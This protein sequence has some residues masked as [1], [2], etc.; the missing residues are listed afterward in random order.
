M[1]DFGIYDFDWIRGTTE[2]LVV[3][4]KINDTPIAADDV[5]LSVYAGNKLAFRMSSVDNPGAGPGMVNIDTGVYTFQPTE[6]QTRSLK[7]SKIG[8][9]GKNSYELAVRNGR[10]ERV[11][12]LGTIAGIGGL[13]DDEAS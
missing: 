2:P 4:L 5:R 8:D 12:M 13:N 11:Y 10:D 3:A 7:Q 6:A 1:A 9:I